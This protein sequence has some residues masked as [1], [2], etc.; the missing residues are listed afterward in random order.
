ML[1]RSERLCGDT[2]PAPGSRH[3]IP[4][5]SEIQAGEIHGRNR[6]AKSRRERTRTRESNRSSRDRRS[7]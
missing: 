7:P 3:T 1:I 2:S 6:W 5:P 4:A